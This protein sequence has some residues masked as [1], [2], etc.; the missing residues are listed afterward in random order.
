M[1]KFEA[2]F[3]E[4]HQMVIAK[5]SAGF[6]HNFISK[7][8]LYSQKFDSKH[9]AIQGHFPLTAY[10]DTLLS[11]VCLNKKAI[12]TIRSLPDLIVSHYD[13]VNT[14]IYGPHDFRIV[15]AP[16][17][18]LNWSNLSE[19]SRLDYI[20]K[21][22]CPWYIRFVNSW[23]LSSRLGW[24]T[25][26]IYFEDYTRDIQAVLSEVN[27]KLDISSQFNLDINPDEK[28]NYNAGKNGRGKEVLSKRQ[29]KEIQTMVELL[30]PDKAM[31]NYLMN[32]K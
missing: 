4:T 18:N 14:R 9:V 10:N 23:M 1:R 30:I 31:Q 25:Q 3:A 28:V 6:G 32:G 8:R 17:E 13:H 20:I 19:E 15:D 22:C 16:I 11:G 24:N 7:E 5:T 2:M 21:F 27:D 12:C 26:I 29:L